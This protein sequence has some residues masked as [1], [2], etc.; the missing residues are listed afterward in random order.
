[1][2]IN[3][4]YLKNI[5][6]LKGFQLRDI[7][8]LLEIESVNLSHRVNNHKDFKLDEVKTISD[9]LELTDNELMEIFFPERRKLNEMV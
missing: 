2:Q 7:A 5:L 8:S 1:M 3:T 4:Q 6:K 9:Y